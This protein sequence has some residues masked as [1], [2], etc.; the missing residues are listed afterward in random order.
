MAAANSGDDSPQSSCP[1]GHPDA[2][3]SIPCQSSKHLRKVV[4]ASVCLEKLEIRNREPSGA[5]FSRVGVDVIDLQA[6]S[7]R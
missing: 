1:T 5:A 4:H 3:H 2:E 7:S 6:D